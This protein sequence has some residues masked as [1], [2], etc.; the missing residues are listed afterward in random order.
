V[1]PAIL[2]LAV[3]RIV[4]TDAGQEGRVAYLWQRTLEGLLATAAGSGG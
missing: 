4:G 3:N 1:V 2:H